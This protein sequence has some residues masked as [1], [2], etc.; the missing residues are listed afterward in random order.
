QALIQCDKLG[1]RQNR[2]RCYRLVFDIISGYA[3]ITPE[4]ENIRD[5]ETGCFISGCQDKYPGGPR[6]GMAQVTDPVFPDLN[7]GSAYLRNRSREERELRCKRLR[8]VHERTACLGERPN[9]MTMDQGGGVRAGLVLQA[10]CTSD[11]DPVIW[12][13]CLRRTIFFADNLQTFSV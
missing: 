9:F 8:Y 12:E 11:P 4:N 7:P 2:D 10:V 1:I 13:G 5:P 3:D 6:N